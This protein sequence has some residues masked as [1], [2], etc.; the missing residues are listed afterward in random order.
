MPGQITALEVQA[1]NK[2]RVNVYLDGEYAFA[3]PLVEAARLRR[4]QVLT[5]AEIAEL[6]ARDAVATALDRA[7]RF[8]SYRPRSISEV[9]RN[10]QEKGV[11]P[12]VI[13]QV[14]AELERLGYLDDLAF[15]RYWVQNR[16]EF[17]PRGPLALRQELKQKGIS[18][19]IITQVLGEVDFAEAAYRAARAQAARWT[20]LNRQVFRQKLYAYLAR[21]GFPT[22]TCREVLDRLLAELELPADDRIDDDEWQE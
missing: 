15:A 16:D 14:I 8:L 11:E 3:L 13:D 1:R 12:P 21:R 18:G 22:E 20:S 6:K 7:V 10:L 5:E 19:S 4:G 2:E 17:R 9:R